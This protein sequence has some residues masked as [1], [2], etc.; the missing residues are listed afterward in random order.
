MIFAVE[1]FINEMVDNKM[2]T[3]SQ[4]LFTI[5]SFYY[6]LKGTDMEGSTILGT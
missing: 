6:K 4:N 3:V 1:I 2:F 5:L